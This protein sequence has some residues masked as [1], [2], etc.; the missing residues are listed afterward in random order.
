MSCYRPVHHSYLYGIL[1]F[2]D[3]FF[4]ILI[5]VSVVGEGRYIIYIYIYI[6]GLGASLQALGKV[7]DALV[8]ETLG[9]CESTVGHQS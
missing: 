7:D 2:W 3:G 6:V 4:K 1:G 9:R 8:E 5:V